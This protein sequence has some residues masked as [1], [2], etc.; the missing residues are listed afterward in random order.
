M[1][2]W[3]VIFQNNE[4]IRTSF[5]SALAL[6]YI[7]ANRE[8]ARFVGRNNGTIFLNNRQILLNPVK[9][10]NISTNTIIA[11][12]FSHILFCNTTKKIFRPERY[13]NFWCLDRFDISSDNFCQH[14]SENSWQHWSAPSNGLC[15]FS[16]NHFSVSNNWKN[17]LGSSPIPSKRPYLNL[18][19][20]LESWL[21]H[22]HCDRILMIKFYFRVLVLYKVPA[23]LLCQEASSHFSCRNLKINHEFTWNKN[24]SSTRRRITGSSVFSVQ[25]LT[26]RNNYSK[27]KVAH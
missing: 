4:H 3:F 7:F 14:R 1:S 2:L 18:F 16:I 26:H 12:I 19:L 11:S 27:L 8:R 23:K 5:A 9:S 24:H 21:I 6:S 25:C 15:I 17:L 22:E 10:R 13:Y 20:E